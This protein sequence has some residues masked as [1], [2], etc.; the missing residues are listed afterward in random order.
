VKPWT[1]ITGNCLDHLPQLQP[2]SVDHVITDP[3]YEAE[4]HTK[5][6]RLKRGGEMS[7]EPLAFP[8]ITTDE[9]ENVAAQFG[10]LSK[11]W[12]LAFCQVEAAPKWTACMEQY[13]LQY[14]RT[15]IWHKPD[16]MPQYTGDRPGMGY[17]TMVLCHPPGR[18]RWNGGG[19][20]GVYVHNKNE[21]GSQ[22]AAHQT[23][24]PLSL[25]LELVADFTDPGDL[26]LDPYCGSGTTGVACLRLGRRFLGFE[27]NPQYAEL[28]RERL[29]A[30]EQGLSLRDARHGQESL[31]RGER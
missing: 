20:V 2:G 9:R 23:Q 11:R 1:V 5:Q 12:V 30:E 16:A 15:M 7:T 4:A 29:S 24:K 21:L 28:A 8:P 19:R 22:K 13:G 3:P 18:K 14:V 31:F 27:I 26:V 6:R 10:R 17:E 25:M